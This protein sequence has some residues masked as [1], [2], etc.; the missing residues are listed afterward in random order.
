MKKTVFANKLEG[1]TIEVDPKDL[2]FRVSVYGVLIQDGKILLSPWWDGWDFPGGGLEL[3]ETLEEGLLREFKEETGLEVDPGEFILVGQNF[4]VSLDT[5]KPRNSFCFY[6][7]CHNP[8]GEITAEYFTEEE[9]KNSEGKAK[10][11]DVA[12][13]KNIKFYQSLGNAA[14]I[15]EKAQKMLT[16]SR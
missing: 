12:E 13:A 15:I 14:E 3:D 11:F 16:Q 10:W 4:F 2:R 9:K 1:G 8:R 7:M 6:Y 5:T